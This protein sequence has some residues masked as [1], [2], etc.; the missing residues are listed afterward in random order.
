MSTLFIVGLIIAFAGGLWLLIVAFEKSVWWGLGCLFIPFASLLFVILNWRATWKPFVIN[1]VGGILVVVGLGS[2]LPNSEQMALIGKTKQDLT[3]QLEKGEISEEQAAKELVRMLGAMSK[4]ETYVPGSTTAKEKDFDPADYAPAAKKDG[5][6][7]S[8]K[9]Q[10]QAK[11]VEDEMEAKR[12][13]LAEDE[14]L[15]REEFK[16]RYQQL[17]RKKYEFVSAEMSQ[18]NETVGKEIRVTLAGGTVRTGTL[19]EASDDVLVIG[20]KNNSGVFSF[21]VKTKQVV[22]FEVYRRTQ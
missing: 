21:N 10:Q 18:V 5:T 8:D 11:A 22:K 15:R 14:R 6:S 19:L 1:I 7:A 4:G 20:S 16:K 2:A 9:K 3:R 17:N 12:K 13:K